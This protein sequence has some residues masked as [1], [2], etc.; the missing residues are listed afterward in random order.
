MGRLVGQKMAQK[1]GYPLWM[2]PY[3][4][5]TNGRKLLVKTIGVIE[6][7]GEIRVRLKVWR[8]ANLSW[9]LE[10]LAV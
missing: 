8:V 9:T 6:E 7:T 2:A 3:L 4:E 10:Q 5:G 1:I